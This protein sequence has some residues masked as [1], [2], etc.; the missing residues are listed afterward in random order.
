M[1][2]WIWAIAFV[3]FLLTTSL[4]SKLLNENLRYAGHFFLPLYK[5][6]YEIQREKENQQI[7]LIQNLLNHAMYPIVIQNFLFGRLDWGKVYKAPRKLKGTITEM[8]EEWTK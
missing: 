4:F 5:Y 7:F 3:S 6:Y 2:H 8:T 1:R